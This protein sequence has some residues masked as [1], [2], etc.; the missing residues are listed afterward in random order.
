MIRSDLGTYRILPDW[1]LFSGISPLAL[2]VW[3][4]L[5]SYANSEDVA[6]PSL[7]TLAER[8]GTT[9]ESVVRC[10]RELVGIGALAVQRRKADGGGNE[11]NVYTVLF[12]QPEARTP[13]DGTVTTLVGVADHPSRRSRP[14]REPLNENKKEPPISPGAWDEFFAAYPKRSGSLDKAKGQEKF[15]AL[16]KAGVDARS[17]IEGARR[18]REWAAATEHLGTAF[19]KQIPTW[20]NGRCW[21]EDYLLPTNGK[22]PADVEFR[23]E[24]K[25][26]LDYDLKVVDD[27][28]VRVLPGT[29]QRFD[30][31]KWRESRGIPA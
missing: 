22:A 25:A 19:I 26:G 5:A 15:Q 10:T 9:K 27:K 8:C 24:P 17:V 20:L 16:I 21:E 29:S 1:I 31:S 6:W 18:Y 13:S 7:K 4:V 23:K 2:R 28:A 14:E 30:E 3:C 12:A 11:S